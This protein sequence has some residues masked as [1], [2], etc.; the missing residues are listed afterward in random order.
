MNE[1][2]FYKQAIFDH[3]L[4]HEALRAAVRA[5]AASRPKRK[6]RW[7]QRA[8][9]AAACFLALLALGI[10]AVPEARAAMVDWFRTHAYRPETYLALPEGVRDDI[11]SIDGITTEPDLVN[12]QLTKVYESNPLAVYFA[13]TYGV[14]VEKAAYDG[15][16]IYLSGRLKG[17][18]GRWL[19]EQYTGGRK[20]RR[21]FISEAETAGWTKAEREAWMASHGN[22]APES[23]ASTD[24]YFSLTFPDGMVLSGPC[25]LVWDEPTEQL[26]KRVEGIV[27]PDGRYTPEALAQIDALTDAY[28]ERNDPR[29]TANFPLFD[30]AGSLAPNSTARLTLVLSQYNHVTDTEE[31]SIEADLGEMTI[32]TESYKQFETQP[33]VKAQTG[34]LSGTHFVRT[35]EWEQ[36]G[37]DVFTTE[38]VRL[39]DFSQVKLTLKDVLLTATDL[40]LAL[41][42]DFPA[43]W[44]TA[45]RNGYNMATSYEIWLDGSKAGIFGS[46][47]L[48]YNDTDGKAVCMMCSVSPEQLKQAEK[49]E[50]VVRFYAPQ[51]YLILKDGDILKENIPLS[52]DYCRKRLVN[53]VDSIS[54]N[55]VGDWYIF[56]NARLTIPI[57]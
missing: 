39:V 9:Q 13:K 7:G 12:G 37:D 22:F 40:Q 18:F 24:G 32:D 19:I 34:Q 53:A 45:L 21:Q 51:T 55:F 48:R 29:F 47:G 33:A 25:D 35:T 57:E 44:D 3:I 4:D 20:T 56:E 2:A 49:V 54:Y 8:L 14:A 46:A 31:P 10:L 52:E 30:D 42:Y 28:L 38:R 41:Q 50:L 17:E 36:D 23:W 16:N 27:G 1:H 6:P 43:D 26:L 5:P 15:E 11:P